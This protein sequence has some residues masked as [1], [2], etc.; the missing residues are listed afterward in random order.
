MENYISDILRLTTFEE[1]LKLDQ[2]LNV[3]SEK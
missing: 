3:M 2:G 1:Y